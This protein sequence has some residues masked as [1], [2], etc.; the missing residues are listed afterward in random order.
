LNLFFL[1]IAATATLILNS[2]YQCLTKP[3]VALPMAILTAVFDNLIVFSG[4]VAYD[5][6]KLI[7]L[8][9]GV[10]PIEDFA[11]TIAAILLIPIIW[12]AMTK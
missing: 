6:S 3:V 8:K 5:E 9:I 10:V 11:Y 2:R 4:I 12:K 1:A 7:G